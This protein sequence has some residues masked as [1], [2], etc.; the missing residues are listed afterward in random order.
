MTVRTAWLL[1]EGQTREDTRLAP[2]GTMTPNGGGPL[3]SRGGVIAGGDPFALTGTG[4][5]TAQVGLGRALVQG[6]AAQGAYPVAVTAPEA[7][8]FDDGDA[9][10]NRI[11]TVCL[12]TYDA[13]YDAS[14]QTLAAVEVIRGTAAA[15]PAAPAMP[16]GHLRLWDV[17]V[18]AGTSAGVGGIDWPSAVAD[19]RAYTSS[20]GGITPPGYNSTWSGA[21]VGQWRDNAG[22][23]ERWDGAAWRVYRA[24]SL[25]AETT[26][27]G[28]SASTG[29]S[30]VAFQGARIAGVATLQY[31]VTRTGATLTATSTGH[32][33]DVQVGTLPAGW[34][35]RWDTEA[36]AS[37]GYGDGAARIGPDGAI[38]LRTWSANGTI[39]KDRT[40]RITP[41]YVL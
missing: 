14:G 25:A 33:V 6:T 41:T 4:A 15:T 23:L 18:R 29:F 8:T 26:S 2:L 28:A 34:R 22:T 7:V 11:D 35:P 36:C 9:N 1:P 27:S 3:T 39:E 38:V 24:P 21:Y 10:F 16:A 13:L 37:D 31:E 5:M 20:Y 17:T 32:L 12:R 30:L 40:I 19:R